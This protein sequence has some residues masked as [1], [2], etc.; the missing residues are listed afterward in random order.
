MILKKTKISEKNKKYLFIILIIAFLFVGFP[1]ID[2][3]F[4]E[5][6]IEISCLDGEFIGFHLMKMPPLCMACPVTCKASLEAYVD[7]ELIC[8]SSV[9]AISYVSIIIPCKELDYHIGEEVKLNYII[10]SNNGYFEKE[11][12]VKIESKE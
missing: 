10:E 4:G 1:F 6:G 12:S 7:G 2:T 5:R 11:T 9:N 8:N 3:L